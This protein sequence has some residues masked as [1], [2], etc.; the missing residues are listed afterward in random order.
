MFWPIMFFMM[1]FA[2]WGRCFPRVQCTE[3]QKHA[4]EGDGIDSLDVQ[5]LSPWQLPLWS[6]MS[7]WVDDRAM[8]WHDSKARF[9]S[10]KQMHSI[11]THPYKALIWNGLK[12][13][14]SSAVTFLV[15]ISSFPPWASILSVFGG[16][17]NGSAGG[18]L[19]GSAD[20]AALCRH[21][22]TSKLE[23]EKPQKFSWGFSTHFS[24]ESIHNHKLSCFFWV[25]LTIFWGR[26]LVRPGDET[27]ETTTKNMAVNSYDLCADDITQTP[28]A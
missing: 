19:V 4:G 11:S 25:L 3:Q 23:V 17:I 1:L 10:M 9:K 18:F 20:A 14:R 28:G 27:G 26:F 6:R 12:Y 15:S 8:M 21:L 2:I 16:E 22:T 7:I 5:T 13:F 24:M